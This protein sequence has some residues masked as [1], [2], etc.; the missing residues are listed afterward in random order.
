M[1]TE[2]VIGALVV[3][4]IIRLAIATVPT[5]TLGITVAAAVPT[6]F[7]AYDIFV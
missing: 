1:Y 6:F 3:L 5:V 4:E 2:L 7:E